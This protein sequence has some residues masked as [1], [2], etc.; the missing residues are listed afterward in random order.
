[1][2]RNALLLVVTLA[3]VALLARPAAAY[4]REVDTQ[5]SVTGMARAS[6]LVT[7][8]RCVDFDEST[9]NGMSA[10]AQLWACKLTWDGTASPHDH[11]IGFETASG[12]AWIKHSYN[13]VDYCLDVA[14]GKA[15]AGAPVRWWKC[16]GSKAQ[17]WYL[18][19][20]GGRGSIRSDLN[21][22]LCL[23]PVHGFNGD[24]NGQPLELWNCH[25]GREQEFGIGKMHTNGMFDM[26]RECRATAPSDKHGCMVTCKYNNVNKAKKYYNYDGV[27][28]SCWYPS[29]GDTA[30]CVSRLNPA[31]YSHDR[32]GNHDETCH[33]FCFIKAGSDW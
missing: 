24:R 8:G 28:Y 3:A 26:E 16:N 25:G 33:C 31:E 17:A 6:D 21:Y 19:G 14:E 11:K 32:S 12:W 5:L 30:R 27:T 10:T 2:Q 20:K 22:N 1:M 18:T 9:A 13:G 4:W 23:D 15:Y 7:T 29:L